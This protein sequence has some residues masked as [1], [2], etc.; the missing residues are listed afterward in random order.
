MIRTYERIKDGESCGV[1]NDPV[2]IDSA[3]SEIVNSELA[4]GAKVE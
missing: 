3:V 1:S 2:S 4:W